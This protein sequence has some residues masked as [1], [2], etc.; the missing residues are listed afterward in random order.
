[1]KKMTI[2]KGFAIEAIILGFALIG[3]G[4]FLSSKDKVH[5][6]V[7]PEIDQTSVIDTQPV[8]DATTTVELETTT[9][10]EIQ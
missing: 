7:Q 6:Q 5:P 1:M 4:S 3:L 9:E 2:S 10:T 8:M